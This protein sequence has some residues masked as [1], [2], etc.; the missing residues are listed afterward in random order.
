MRIKL[1]SLLCVAAAFATGCR[2]PA[3]DLMNTFLLRSDDLDVGEA[4]GVLLV[5]LQPQLAATGQFAAD[6]LAPGHIAAEPDTS[7][8][9]VEVM[10][11]TTA[12]AGE[13]DGELCLTLNA[14]GDFITFQPVTWTSAAAHR[15]YMYVAPR[16]LFARIDPAQGYVA[17]DVFLLHEPGPWQAVDRAVR[18]AA[19]QLGARPFRP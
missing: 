16:S 17:V 1:I 10:H 9:G 18:D 19:Q 8:P 2:E 3:P 6:Q 11:C 4:A 14:A 5:A 12:P 13:D 7:D 15:Y